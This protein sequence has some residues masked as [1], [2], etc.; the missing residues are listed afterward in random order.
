MSKSLVTASPPYSEVT[1][2]FRD[3]PPIAWY[4]AIGS[5]AITEK[6]RYIGSEGPRPLPPAARCGFTIG[7]DEPRPLPPAA[8]CGFIGTTALGPFHQR[9]NVTSAPQPKPYTMPCAA[10]ELCLV[11]NRTPQAPD[12]HLCRGV[13]GRRLHGL[14]GE[15]EDPDSDEPMHRICQTCAIAKAT[16]TGSS[17]GGKSM[18]TGKRKADNTRGHGNIGTSKK[19]A[20]DSKS[21]SRTWL[22][23]GQKI[24]IL[25]LLREKVT[26]GEIARRFKC[27]A[28]AIGKIAE[29][30]AALEEDHELGGRGSASKSTRG[31]AFPK[32]CFS[33]TEV[34]NKNRMIL[35][36]YDIIFYFV[37]TR[38]FL[39]FRG[40]LG[41]RL[42]AALCSITYFLS[43]V[44]ETIAR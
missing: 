29:E 1:S 33:S 12:G 19:H 28:T 34:Y 38:F 22:N 16:A 39:F 2:L 32:V 14:C 26:Y 42:Y 23:F 8:E 30:R 27:G 17:S 24:E 41:S 10:R 18:S 7:T 11:Q 40:F 35:S 25:G 3:D 4:L 5:A 6:P 13:C 21:K 20:S 37:L 36:R 31:G 9:P 43:A 15:V 44:Q